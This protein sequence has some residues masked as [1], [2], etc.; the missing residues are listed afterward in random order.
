MTNVF[1]GSHFFLARCSIIHGSER[2]SGGVVRAPDP[3]GTQLVHGINGLVP[4]VTTEIVVGIHA[5]C[6]DGEG[7]YCTV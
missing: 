2:R 4:G 7:S 5:A 1:L 3:F 6:D